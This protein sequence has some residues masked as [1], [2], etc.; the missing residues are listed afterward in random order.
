MSDKTSGMKEQIY[1]SALQ[2]PPGRYRHWDMRH[3]AKIDNTTG[4]IE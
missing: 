1:C 2:T 4:C 3:A